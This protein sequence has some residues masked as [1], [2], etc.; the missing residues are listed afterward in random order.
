MRR[1]TLVLLFAF[2]T[3]GVAMSTV[4]TKR[5]GVTVSQEPLLAVVSMVTPGTSRNEREHPRFLRRELIHTHNDHYVVAINKAVSLPS[6]K[7]EEVDE[8]TTTTTTTTEVTPRTATNEGRADSSSISQT[9]AEV[10]YTEQGQQN[11]FTIGQCLLTLGQYDINNNLQI[12]RT[13]FQYVVN[14]VCMDSTS[15]NT[16]T[17]SSASN[18]W[19]GIFIEAACMCRLYTESDS[20]SGSNTTATSKNDCCSNGTNAMI[21]RPGKYSNNY[22]YTI[23][24]YLHE[25]FVQYKCVLPNDSGT[26]TISTSSAPIATTA[27]PTTTPTSSPSSSNFIVITKAPVMMSVPILRVPIT[28]KRNSSASFDNNNEISDN[29]NSTSGKMDTLMIGLIVVVSIVVSSIVVYMSIK[30]G[31]KIQEKNKRLHS[32]GSMS[33]L[34]QQP[35]E[36]TQPEETEHSQFPNNNN[37][38][39]QPIQSQPNFRDYCCYYFPYFTRKQLPPSPPKTTTLI[40]A[41]AIARGSVIKKRQLQTSLVS[42]EENNAEGNNNDITSSDHKTYDSQ[43]SQPKRRHTGSSKNNDDIV[44]LVVAASSSSTDE[45]MLF[46]DDNDSSSDDPTNSSSNTTYDTTIRHNDKNKNMMTHQDMISKKS[47]KHSRDLSE[48]SLSKAYLNLV[49]SSSLPNYQQYYHN[50]EV[51]NTSNDLMYTGSNQY[52]ASN[53]KTTPVMKLLHQHNTLIYNDNEAADH[54]NDNDESIENINLNDDTSES[55][56][57]SSSSTS[58][59]SYKNISNQRILL[60]Q[61]QQRQS[62][63]ALSLLNANDVDV[64]VDG[65]SNSSSASSSTSSQGIGTTSSSS[66]AGVVSNTSSMVALLSDPVPFTTPLYNKY[67]IYHH[68]HQ[69]SILDHGTTSIITQRPTTIVATTSNRNQSDNDETDDMVTT[70]PDEIISKTLISSSSISLFEPTPPPFVITP[71]CNEVTKTS[72]NNDD[73]N[74]HEEESDDSNDDDVL[75]ML[76]RHQPTMQTPSQESKTLTKSNDD[77]NVIMTPMTTKGRSLGTGGTPIHISPTHD[78]YNVI[79]WTENPKTNNYNDVDRDDNVNRNNSQDSG[80]ISDRPSNDEDDA[81]TVVA[82]NQQQHYDTSLIYEMK[83]LGTKSSFAKLREESQR[84]NI[85]TPPKMVITKKESPR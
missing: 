83:A 35:T 80:P 55:S 53:D 58:D 56:S 2:V 5:N 60:Q 39:N 50:E 33:P 7:D 19:D 28:T 84:T 14:H 20:N 15:T 81:T 9:A 68:H 8:A 52:F 18:V 61:H 17:N 73:G 75:L 69:S 42:N 45:A 12:N 11:N 43:S 67:D 85:M 4:I 72:K 64:D 13:E 29:T 41:E 22:T 78:D 82:S 66:S 16:D 10:I 71:N 23:C 63:D 40:A 62:R 59:E 26:A 70:N 54:D 76:R 6:T 21:Y 30:I 65:S 37:N 34:E 48:T 32:D 47:S 25:Q 77:A 38:N 46:D 49:P 57:A 36:E 44:V 3:S 27:L 74:R 31:R 1:M 24:Q 79:Q 51:Y